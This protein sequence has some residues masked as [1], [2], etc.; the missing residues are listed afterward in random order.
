MSGLALI[1]FAYSLP[2]LTS[3][4]LYGLEAAHLAQAHMQV[5]QIAMQVADNASRVRSSIDETDIN[6]ALTGAD[7]IG[8]S[9]DFTANGRIILSSLEPNGLTG[10]DEGQ[11]IRWQRCYGDGDYASSYGASGDGETGS[12]LADGM[13]PAGNEVTA[14]DG[15][16]VIF[17]E[18]IYDYQ[19]LISNKLFGA[20]TIR[21]NSAFVVRE[22]TDQS[23]KNASNLSDS[24][25]ALCT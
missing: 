18:V 16:A 5:S 8:E 9:I 25:K 19:P 11:Y 21:Y 14:M 24:A 13:G 7:M 1:E 3:L 4:G 12:T 15:S 23:M 22:R 10:A 2:V 6:E 17:A 20:K